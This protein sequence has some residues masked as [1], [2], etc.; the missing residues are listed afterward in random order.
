VLRAR[1][2]DRWPAHWEQIQRIYNLPDLARR[3][4]LLDMIAQTLPGLK[5]GQTL[6]AARLYRVY[7]DLWLE[8][9]IA[10]GRTLLT[11]A[12]RRLFAEELV[13]SA[14]FDKLRTGSGERGRRTRDQGR[15]GEGCTGLGRIEQ[16]IKRV[17]R[18]GFDQ[19]PDSL[20]YW[21]R[22]QCKSGLY[23]EIPR[24]PSALLRINFVEGP[25]EPG[26]AF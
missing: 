15:R 5:E 24:L 16:R 22:L 3:P 6:N 9:E 12:D 11:P 7:T 8:R 4:V 1:F 13:P 2:P 23:I 18:I 14:S 21:G 19:S 10:K 20:F 17:N 26:F 25:V